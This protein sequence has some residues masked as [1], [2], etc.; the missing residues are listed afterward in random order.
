MQK[1]LIPTFLFEIEDLTTLKEKGAVYKVGTT[2]IGKNVVN[3]VLFENLT[4]DDVFNKLEE[5]NLFESAGIGV[6]SKSYASRMMAIMFL[7][8][9]ELMMIKDKDL[10]TVGACSLIAANNSLFAV[11]P[12]YARRILPI[13]RSL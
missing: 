7:R 12:A 1:T 11:E 6:D 5:D 10:R 13:L 4:I 2:K 3:C 8:V 9:R